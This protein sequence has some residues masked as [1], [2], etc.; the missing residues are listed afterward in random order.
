MAGP[1]SSREALKGEKLSQREGMCVRNCSAGG[2]RVARLKAQRA[3]D[4]GPQSLERQTQPHPDP[5]EGHSLT[6]TW[7]LAQGDPLWVYE[8]ENF[9]ITDACWF[10]A[11]ES[12]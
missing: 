3:K 11:P 12:C 7:I 2:G 6:G 8:L 1:M 10:M 9:R 4:Q 5:A